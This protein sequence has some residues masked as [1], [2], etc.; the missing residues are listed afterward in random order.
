MSFAA[1]L[2]MVRPEPTSRD[3]VAAAVSK[4]I[5][6]NGIEPGVLP[7]MLAQIWLETASGGSLWQNNVGNITAGEKSWSGPVWR[8]SWYELDESSSPRQIRLHAAMLKG[9]A[10]SAFRAYPTLE[11][12][13]SDYVRRIKFDFSPVLKA[14]KTGRARDTA[15]AIQD[16]NYCPDCELEKTTRTLISLRDSWRPWLREHDYPTDAK[17]GGIGRALIF[18]GAIATAAWLMT[19]EE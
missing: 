16:S 1:E 18:Y 19:I 14:M 5:R 10:P 7:L 3:A 2:P 13:A 12:G 9:E 15:R 8:P 17:P 4:A 6:S 11:A